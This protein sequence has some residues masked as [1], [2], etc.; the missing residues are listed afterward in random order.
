MESASR[1][2]AACTSVLYC[3]SR[4]LLQG[5]GWQGCICSALASEKVAFAFYMLAAV[6]ATP[7]KR[8]MRAC[9][10]PTCC[11]VPWKADEAA[12]SARFKLAGVR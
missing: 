8:A 5:A 11:R 4:L 9:T 6:P 10:P 7:A 2:H 1:H 12:S 3:L